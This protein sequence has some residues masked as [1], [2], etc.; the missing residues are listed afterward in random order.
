VK[1]NIHVVTAEWLF[2]KLKYTGE[3]RM[4]VKGDKLLSWGHDDW[5]DE[6]PKEYE[7]LGYCV[8]QYAFKIK[9]LGKRCDWSHSV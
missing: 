4:I 3:P 2:K 6:K 8:D 7:F 1:A 5:G 9:C